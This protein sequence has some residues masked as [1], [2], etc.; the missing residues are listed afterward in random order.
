MQY[1]P[2]SAELLSAI[3]DFLIKEVMPVVQ[4]DKALAYK[5]LV[6]WNMLGVVAREIKHDEKLTD[7]ECGRLDSI[8]G[9]KITSQ[10]YSGK[11]E[12]LN[13]RNHE[14]AQKIRSEKISDPGTDIWIHVKKTLIER[15]SV[16][17]PRFN[18]E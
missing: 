3:Q 9:K 15:L 13:K 12:E 14:L 5:T 7:A 1:R 11:L 16:S 18:P 10:T 8:L 6:S 2:E 4:E 17:N